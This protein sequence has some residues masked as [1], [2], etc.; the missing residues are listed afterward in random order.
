MYRSIAWFR[1][2]GQTCTFGSIFLWKQLCL[3]SRE[4]VA[5]V[6]FTQGFKAV[7]HSHLV[8]KTCVLLDFTSN[9]PDRLICPLFFCVGES[10]GGAATKGGGAYS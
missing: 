7:E 2:T 9:F 10:A 8:A 6:G 4:N 3:T 5:S 1:N